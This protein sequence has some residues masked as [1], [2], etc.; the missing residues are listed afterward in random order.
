MFLLAKM[1]ALI[2]FVRMF[3][4]VEST[5]F[6][7]AEGRGHAVSQA[8]GGE[9]GDPLM[10]GLYSIGVHPAL[11]EV[12]SRLQPGEELYAFLDDTYVVSLPDRTAPALDLLGSSRANVDLHLGKTTRAWNAAGEAPPGLNARVPAGPSDPPVWVRDWA[13]PAESQGLVVLGTPMGSDA[14]IQ[15]TLRAK[16][17]DHEKKK[18]K[19]NWTTM[20]L[21]WPASPPFLTCRSPGCFYAATTSCG[22]C[23]QALQANSHGVT[24]QQS[25]DAWDAYSAMTSR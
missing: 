18:K 10:P 16:L 11:Q 1:S 12:H 21:C 23:R 4:G 19:K 9:Q 7:D 6:N 22:F 3:C 5:L 25:S 24:M 15:A 14:F 13:L 17:D 20:R 8:E 2:P